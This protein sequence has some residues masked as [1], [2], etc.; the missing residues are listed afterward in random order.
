MIYVNVECM[1]IKNT[2]KFKSILKQQ[3]RSK[4]TDLKKVINYIHALGTLAG[5]HILF[6]IYND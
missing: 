1:N 3:N 5:K 6:S 2:N 4:T